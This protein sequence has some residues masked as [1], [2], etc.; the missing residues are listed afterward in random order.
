M[1]SA[2]IAALAYRLVS[3]NPYDTFD[4]A[5]PW[6]GVVGN[7]SCSLVDGRLEAAPLVTPQIAAGR[8]SR[9]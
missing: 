8:S 2:P 7:W 4:G 6:R 5:A 9:L 1:S 3:R